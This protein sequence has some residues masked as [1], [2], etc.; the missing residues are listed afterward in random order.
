MRGEPGMFH[1]LGFGS[2]V[3]RRVCRS[4]V[5]AEAYNLDLCIEEADPIRAALADMHGQLDTRR[6]ED[7]AADSRHMCWITDCKSVRDALCR[8]VL[9]KVSDKRLGI[10]LAAMRQ[11][12][13]RRKGGGKILPRLCDTRP[14]D[15]TDSIMWIDTDNMIVDCMTKEMDTESLEQALD[16]N[17][18]D[19]RQSAESKQVKVRKQ[20]SRAGSKKKTTK[21]VAE[22]EEDTPE[23]LQTDT[24]VRE[25]QAGPEGSAEDTPKR[26]EEEDDSAAE[27]LQ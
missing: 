13:W 21:V 23:G 26:T 27:S 20:K 4:T 25:Q 14:E 3:V 1:P 7:S 12:L 18:F 15:A 10:T 9:S 5:Q 6:W 2:G 16:T 11:S 8:P 17:I 24:R 19:P 22:K